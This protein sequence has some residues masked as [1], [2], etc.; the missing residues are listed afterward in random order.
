MPGT[1][2]VRAGTAEA[3]APNPGRQDLG[4]GVGTYSA[5]VLIQR[6]RLFSVGA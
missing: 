3:S 5:S 1:P 6:R 4:L 2:A